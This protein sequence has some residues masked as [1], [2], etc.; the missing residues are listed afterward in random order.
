MAYKNYNVGTKNE[1]YTITFMLD[2]E[3]DKNLKDLEKTFLK[4]VSPKLL[5]PI[6]CRRTDYLKLAI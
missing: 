2:K 1:L 4:K 6:F 3:Q 5:L